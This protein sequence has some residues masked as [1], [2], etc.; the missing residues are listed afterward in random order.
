LLLKEIFCDKIMSMKSHLKNAFVPHEGNDYKPHLLRRT[1]VL[2]VVALTLGVF[3]FGYVQ[4]TLLFSD[5][6]LATIYPTLVATLS[7]KNRE[8]IQ[9]PA[10]AYS[11]L[12]E[13]AAR[14]K[15]EDMKIKGYFAHVSPEGVEPWH[16]IKAAGYNYEYAGENLAINFSD[17]ADVTKAWMDSPGHRANILSKNFTEVGV[18]TVKGFVDGRRTIFVVEMFG[19]PAKDM[20]TSTE[21]ISGTN[22]ATTASEIEV[23]PTETVKDLS[24]T[25]NDK[26]VLGLSTTARP[27]EE[28]VNAAGAFT[29]L[30]L[31]I[32]NPRAI[33]LS[34]YWVL[35]IATLLSISLMLV[36]FKRR[37]IP[38]I[39]FGVCILLWI[40]S[41]ILVY[42]RFF[43]P[44]VIVPQ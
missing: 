41:C 1:G 18:A 37:H 10:L 15:A 42:L 3:T 38:H 14:L 17:S 9:L 6:M 2:V 4:R 16:W 40:L 26:A 33:L 22:D 32:S 30:S 39:L 28:S 8:D 27:I 11:P 31:L 19:S 23:S 43:G 21:V 20:L 12:L 34:I 25:N 35:S 13:E 5:R 44:S 36:F 24:L 29:A 7:N